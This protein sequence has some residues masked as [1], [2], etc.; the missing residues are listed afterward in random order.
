MIITFQGKYYEYSGAGDTNDKGLAIGGYESAF[1]ADL[2]ASYL[3]EKSQRHFAYAIYNGIYRDD[4]FLVLSGKR[5]KEQ[6]KTWLDD[7][8]ETIN[9][10]TR[11]KYFQ[12][13]GT[14]WDQQIVES[15]Q[16]GSL[17]IST[18]RKF[19]FLDMN[20]EWSEEGP[21]QF[22]VYRKP[23]QAL[24]YLNSHITH[25]P[26]TTKAIASG[27]LMHLSRLIS[28]T[29]N[30][31]ETPMNLLYPDHAAALSIAKLAPEIYPILEEIHW[32]IFRLF[33][34]RS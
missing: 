12:F 1:L 7:F 18:E 29:E 9:A 19:P 4:G 17:S 23:G 25:T 26:S 5:N 30:S 3:F 14:L 16:I 32:G 34:D 27:V 8:Q 22:S 6:M 31:K 11:G 20:V 24:K 10:L 21:I 2:V 28:I 15:S 33:C 13:T